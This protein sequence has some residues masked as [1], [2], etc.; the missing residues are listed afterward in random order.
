MEQRETNIGRLENW[1]KLG[2][3]HFDTRGDLDM[4]YVLYEVIP[5]LEEVVGGA[6][7]N[8]REHHRVGSEQD[9][10]VTHYTSVRTVVSML[11]TLANGEPAC[12]RLY[13]SLHQNDPWEG[14]HLARML[15]YDPQYRWLMRGESVDSGHAY[16]V[17]FV[18]NANAENTEDKLV[19][20]RT[21]GDNGRGCSLTVEVPGPILLEVKY[22]A[23]GAAYAKEILKPMLD[24]VTSLAQCR[25]DYADK[26]SRAIWECLSD[27]KYLYK[28]GAY[29]FEKE[30]RVLR[31]DAN[32]GPT[33]F[34]YDRTADLLSEV[35]HYRELE[36]LRL[37]QLLAKSGSKIVVGP[38]AK[39]KHSVRL[40]LEDLRDKIKE[41]Y[42]E[43][44][45]EDKFQI[46]ESRIPYRS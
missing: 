33:Q 9:V 15:A 28:D 14:G 44:D 8:I 2:K 23:Q 37:L 41:R 19:L 27:V 32:P 20:W 7:Q 10:L 13:D 6:A 45:F 34:E 12:L 46:L 36:E 35:R 4:R 26:I 17:S 39:D 21:Y 11:Q 43:F 38:T 40:Y 31:D 29:K 30:C 25:D 18:K 24:A 16:L 1:V 3:D 5:L 42:Q 22:G